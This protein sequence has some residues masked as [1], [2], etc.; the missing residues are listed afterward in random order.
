[1]KRLLLL[2]L[3][4]PLAGAQDVLPVR[5]KVAASAAAPA[6]YLVNQGF[7][8][9]GYDN[10]ET[11]TE[12]ATP[13][14]NPDYTVTVLAGSQS[15][16]AALNS[17]SWT[18]FAGQTVCEYFVLFRMTALPTS[19]LRQTVY[20]ANA[21]DTVEPFYHVINPDGTV[22]VVTS[23]GTSSP[24]ATA[25]SINTTYK[26]YGRYVSGGTCSI[27]ITTGVGRPTVDGSG[28]VYLTAT[29][30]SVTVS[31]LWL[32]GGN[33]ATLINIHDHVLLDDAVIAANP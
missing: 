1:M 33:D 5:R 14:P 11:W 20:L 17:F 18:S 16:V 32:Y 9:T 4:M 30:A 12:R 2:L 28:D 7:E 3:M 6:T 10:G 25:L 22:R 19:T 24:S 27:G 23:G 15:F 21:G 8:G 29:A 26:L 31:E 13:A